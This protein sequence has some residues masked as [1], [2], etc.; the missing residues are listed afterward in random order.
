MW[1]PVVCRRD[2]TVRVQIISSI[3]GFKKH[4]VLDGDTALDIVLVFKCILS[5]HEVSVFQHS[6]LS[7][8]PAFLSAGLPKQNILDKTWLSG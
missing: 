7:W 2:T 3:S 8:L 6:S 1:R 5:S 4:I